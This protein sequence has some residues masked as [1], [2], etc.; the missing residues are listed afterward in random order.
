LLT[1]LLLD[2][3]KS[4]A[5]ET[6]VQGRIINV[7]SIAHK[8]SD[9]TCFELNKL[10]DKARLAKCY[11][12]FMLIDFGYM[13][14]RVISSRF[15]SFHLQIYRY[16]PFIAYAHSKLANILHANELARRFKVWN[17]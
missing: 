12:L 1:N 17:L 14:E 7:S 5:R 2:K 9:G 11:P 6:G 3:M 15:F 10:N 13:H 16:Q 8:R 4:T